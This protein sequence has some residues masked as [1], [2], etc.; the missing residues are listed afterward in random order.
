MRSFRFHLI[1]PQMRE[2][3]GQR[4]GRKRWSERVVD[5]W[6]YSLSCG[7]LADFQA[8]HGDFNDLQLIKRTDWRN[9]VGCL[10][11]MH[12][13]IEL[14]AY[15]PMFTGPWRWLERP[16]ACCIRYNR[17]FSM[18]ESIIRIWK[19]DEKHKHETVMSEVWC[20]RPKN[21]PR[22][23][24][25][26][27]TTGNGDNWLLL[28]SVVVLVGFLSPVCIHRTSLDSVHNVI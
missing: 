1:L 5:K 28:V 20:V 25:G 23:V 3:V 15:W 6:S 26:S 8:C 14:G 2:G 18:Q 19:W 11:S 12:K 21:L 27:A 16:P 9:L 4:V 13:T 22:G 24:T 10:L 7:V 17:H